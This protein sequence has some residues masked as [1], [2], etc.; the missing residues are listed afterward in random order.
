MRA[1]IGEKIGAEKE[2]N[3][4]IS[5][6]PNMCNI[7]LLSDYATSIDET[8]MCG[9]SFGYSFSSNK[10]RYINSFKNQPPDTFEDSF[11]LNLSL[12][13]INDVTIYATDN[14]FFILHLSSAGESSSFNLFLKKSWYPNI[15]FVNVR[16]I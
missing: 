2:K 7:E 6:S 1:R 11:G 4:K 3:L 8:I 10:T 12:I 16:T 5:Y 13:K 15:T 9:S 14:S